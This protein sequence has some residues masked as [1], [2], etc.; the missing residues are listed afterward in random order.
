MTVTD[1]YKII[2]NKIKANQAQYDLDRVAAKKSAYSYGDLR[3]YEYLTSEKLGYKSSVVEQAN[4]SYSP[5]GKVF[6]KG[7][8]GEGK[9]KEF[10]IVLKILGVETKSC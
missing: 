3:K 7:L 8:T 9:K 2:Y 10:W 5:L 6:N 1:R 4:F